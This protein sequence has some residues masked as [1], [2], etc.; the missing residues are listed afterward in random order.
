MPP[1]SGGFGE[2]IEEYEVL[3]LLGKG[4]FASVYQAKCRRTGIEV[5]IKMIDKKKMQA[6]GMVGRVRQE[7]GIHSRLKHP[8]IIEPYTFFEDEN[9]VYLVLEL[10]HN[11]ELQRF[12]R[13]HY[14]KGFPEDQ[15]AKIMKQVVQGLLYL[16]SHQ[17]LHRDMSLANLLLTKDMQVKI[18]DFGLATQLSRPDEKHMTMCGTPNYISPEVATRSS[19]GLEADVWGLGCMLYTLLVGKPPF[20]TDAVK[21]TLALV[22]MAD[23]KMP[24]HLSDNAKNLIDRLLKKNPRDRIKLREI[25]KHPFITSIDKQQH[26]QDKVV[27]TRA[28]SG[29]LQVD[30]G[31]GRTLSSL[32]RMPR[33]RSRSEERMSMAPPPGSHFTARSDPTN[34]RISRKNNN[35]QNN[36]GYREKHTDFCHEQTSVLSGIPPPPLSRILSQGSHHT[37]HDDARKVNER[38]ISDRNKRHEQ[39][40]VNHQCVKEAEENIKIQIPPFNSERLLPTRHRTK[41]A[42]LTILENGEVCIEFLKKKNGKSE[43]ISEVCRISSDGLRIL[44][45]K[46]TDSKIIRDAPPPIPSCG[47]DNMY[48]YE[49]LPLRH[50]RKYLYAARFVNLV[51]AKTPKLTLYTTRGKCLFMENGPHPDCELYFYNG[52]KVTRVDSVVKLTEQNG[53]ASYTEENIPGDLEIYYEHYTESYQRC[54]LLESTL[55]SLQSATGHSYFPAIIGRKPLSALNNTPCSQG[56]E[57]I[58]RTT[59]SPPVMMSFDATCSVTSAIT[60]RTKKPLSV[61]SSHYGFNT[62]N[63]PGV[64]VATQLPSGDVKIEYKDGCSLTVSPQSCGGGILYESPNGMIT[65]YLKNHNVEVP[66]EIR[67][68]LQYLPTIIKYLV[69]PRHRN[70]R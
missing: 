69:Q 68:K 50:H 18:A 28:I 55:A 51:K 66:P 11:G 23:Y 67:E 61:R 15:A 3:N 30:S 34:I 47:A 7:I 54:L 39:V 24:S 70:I 17:I 41:N 43:R 35:P 12:L 58:S 8:S 60:S 49:N 2:R 13:A 64:G 46:P 59:N 27:L 19:H 33:L 16:H 62:V 57:N 10:C 26:Y 42:V 29:D 14:P 1:L 5:A 48:S 38:E 37:V 44:L 63:V 45:Y 20:D 4:G 25:L 36:F 32:G 21:R 9:Y 6:A 65:K 31:L 53:M 22:V 56:K 40:I 52:V